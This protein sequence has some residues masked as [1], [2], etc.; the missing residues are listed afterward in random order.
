ML[1]LR[2]MKTKE[3]IM[4]ELTELEGEQFLINS[5][6]TNLK[7]MIAR[8]VEKEDKKDETRRANKKKGR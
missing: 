8:Y 4:N 3:E 2:N 1:D 5:R 7:S 6:I